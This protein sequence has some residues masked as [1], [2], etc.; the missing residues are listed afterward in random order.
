MPGRPRAGREVDLRVLLVV[1]DAEAVA[2]GGE[3]ADPGEVPAQQFLA[4]VDR[5]GA[6]VAGGGGPLSQ[7]LFG[8]APF[9]LGPAAE[10]CCSAAGTRGNSAAVARSDLRGSGR[11]IPAGD[12]LCRKLTGLTLRA[13]SKLTFRANRWRDA[14]C[15]SCWLRVVEPARLTGRTRRTDPQV[16]GGG[17]TTLGGLLA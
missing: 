6:R 9:R 16:T 7:K 8:A 5:D 10:L 13:K 15:S 2:E 17:L 4:D 11:F 14:E 3:V 1:A 12:A